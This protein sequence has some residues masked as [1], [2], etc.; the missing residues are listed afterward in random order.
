MPPVFQAPEEPALTFSFRQVRDNVILQQKAISSQSVQVLDR[1]R[2]QSS[3]PGCKGYNV[4]G[5]GTG[6]CRSRVVSDPSIIAILCVIATL[7]VAGFV[8]L[9]HSGITTAAERRTRNLERQD[10]DYYSGRR[11]RERREHTVRQH[12]QG[13]QRDLSART[14]TD[15]SGQQLQLRERLAELLARHESVL[16][17]QRAQG[18]QPSTDMSR[19]RTPEAAHLRDRERD[20]EQYQLRSNQEILAGLENTRLINPQV[21]SNEA[22]HYPSNLLRVQPSLETLP[23]Y[24]LEDPL[25]TQPASPTVHH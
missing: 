16:A 1:V 12:L 7:C 10:W 6:P 18:L 13:R 21:F 23:E 2:P 11:R 9:K 8:K 5:I 15:L 20:W 14:I 19:L 17:Q 3:K 25:G 22:V 24:A 4:S